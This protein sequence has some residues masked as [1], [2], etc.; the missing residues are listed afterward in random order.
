MRAVI[1]KVKGGAVGPTWRVPRQFPQSVLDL[2]PTA[3]QVLRVLDEV[4]ARLTD[5]PGLI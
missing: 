2:S 5:P 1:D 4:R 3:R